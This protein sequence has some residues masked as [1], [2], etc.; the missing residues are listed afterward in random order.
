[1]EQDLYVVDPVPGNPGIVSIASKEQSSWF[2]SFILNRA[3]NVKDLV[4]V[5]GDLIGD[6][7]QAETVSEPSTLQDRKV[8][9][10][11]ISPPEVQV[12]VFT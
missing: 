10:K 1:M 8:V 5:V 2:I 9:V 12:T 11:E 4:K 6:D 3:D 7:V